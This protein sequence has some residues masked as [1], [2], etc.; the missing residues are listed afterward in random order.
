MVTYNQYRQ[1][2]QGQAVQDVSQSLQALLMY[3]AQREDRKYERERDAKRD[4]MLMRQFRQS[5]EQDTFS[6][7]MARERQD[8]AVTGRTQSVGIATQDKLQGEIETITAEFVKSVEQQMQTSGV[9]LVK[10]DRQEDA[11]GTP[12]YDAIGLNVDY[13]GP[14]ENEEQFDPEAVGLAVGQAAMIAYERQQLVVDQMLNPT[15][16]RN[17]LLAGGMTEQEIDRLASSLE[18][19]VR[20]AIVD[21]FNNTL[22]GNNR[23]ARRAQEMAAGT[24]LANAASDSQRAPAARGLLQF[25][26]EA[27]TP[28]I[29]PTDDLRVAH[30]RAIDLA[31]SGSWATP[32]TADD[33]IRQLQFRKAD[34]TNLLERTNEAEAELLGEFVNR[35]TIGTAE[36][37]DLVKQGYEVGIGWYDNNNKLQETTLSQ[38]KDVLAAQNLDPAMDFAAS[39]TGKL[40][41]FYLAHNGRAAKAFSEPTNRGFH[42]YVTDKRKD[43]GTGATISVG[44]PYD[45]VKTV[46]KRWSLGAT[47]VNLDSVTGASRDEIARAFG[48]QYTGVATSDDSWWR[49]FSRT[50]TL[51]TPSNTVGGAGYRER[52][53]LSF[54]HLT[55]LEDREILREPQVGLNDVLPVIQR[56]FERDSARKA[57]DRQKIAEDRERLLPLT[58]FINPNNGSM[59]R[60]YQNT[61]EYPEGSEQGLWSV[62][63][64][65]ALSNELTN[66]AINK[67]VE[68]ERRAAIIAEREAARAAEQ[69]QPQPQG[70]GPEQLAPLRAGVRNVRPASTASSGSGGG[71]VQR[72][73]P[74]PTE[75]PEDLPVLGPELFPPGSEGD[76]NMQR[77]EL[78]AMEQLRQ[79]DM[80]E[81][82][83][84]RQ[85]GI[86]ETVGRRIREALQPSG[87][88]Y[89]S[90]PYSE[91]SMAGFPDALAAAN[92]QYATSFGPQPTDPAGMSPER[93]RGADF[94]YQPQPFGPLANEELFRPEF[95]QAGNPNGFFGTRMVPTGITSTPNDINTALGGTAPFGPPIPGQV[96]P[97]GYEEYM[98]AIGDAQALFAMSPPDVTADQDAYNRY[99]QSMEM[100][101]ADNAPLTNEPSEDVRLRADFERSDLGKVGMTLDM[102]KFIQ[103]LEARKADARVY[104]KSRT[105]LYPTRGNY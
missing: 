40:D 63:L 55:P 27:I 24:V 101:R 34:T 88:S 95:A 64:H 52:W 19:Q 91:L 65:Q 74:Q 75:D 30:D 18:D 57:T 46:R 45:F 81:N 8:E 44:L 6:Q 3:L 105:Q 33:T 23:E 79:Q 76:L 94:A 59:A 67:R 9:R 43:G 1:M 93:F 60:R 26:P 96:Y 82:A 11:A 72:L 71:V 16:L 104:N 103:E 47:A 12:S 20:V 85:R 39:V 80:F 61:D 4:E 77:A 53:G 51:I 100:G 38:E 13:N 31:I 28:I 49:G 54:D 42:L 22:S 73:Y 50:G 10:T 41:N 90:D 89:M 98:D 5:Q 78:L 7:L 83:Q 48:L 87:M 62:G 32:S 69:E 68:E 92:E 14:I 70:V 99:T 97:V 21:A 25:A 17:D 2:N 29:G 35:M 102:F 84:A 58:S 86:D 37:G 66:R 36:Y 56:A 15:N